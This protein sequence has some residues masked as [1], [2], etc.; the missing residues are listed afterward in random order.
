MPETVTIEANWKETGTQHVMR[1]HFND[2]KNINKEK[3]GL[4]LLEYRDEGKVAVFAPN[5]ESAISQSKVGGMVLTGDP[6]LLPVALRGWGGQ[7]IYF[8]APVEVKLNASHSAIVTKDGDKTVVKVGCQTFSTDSLKE[9]LKA[10]NEY[11][12]D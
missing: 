8:N 12:Q 7:R 2:P 3:L 5:K 11:E 6:V 4:W 10:V 9:L 1:G